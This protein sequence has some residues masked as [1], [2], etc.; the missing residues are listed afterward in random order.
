MSQPI[1]FAVMQLLHDQR[2]KLGSGPIARRLRIDVDRVQA[3]MPK[4]VKRGVLTRSVPAG[5]GYFL[6]SCSDEQWQ[7]FVGDRRR[8]DALILAAQTDDAIS[9]KLKF[10]KMLKQSVHADNPVLA[11]I[12]DDYQKLRCRQSEADGV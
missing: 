9:K 4:L 3:S 5:G 8:N 6:Y 7:E 11:Q 12:M 1:T 10:L 2:C